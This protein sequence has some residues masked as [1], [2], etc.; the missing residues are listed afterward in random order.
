MILWIIGA[1]LVYYLYHFY[2]VV[3]KRY[4]DG[5]LPL[6]LLGN[7]LSIDPVEPGK[8]VN[9]MAKARNG[10]LLPMNRNIIGLL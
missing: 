6:P 5:P 2:I 9:D 8:S 10:M 1:L 3:R 4:P 7:L